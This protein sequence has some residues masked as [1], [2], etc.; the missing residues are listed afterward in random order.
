[1][2]ISNLNGRKTWA[3]RELVW[4]QKAGRG[5]VYIYLYLF[6]SIY[7]YLLLSI[8]IYRIYI[9][10]YLSL[11]LSI[12]IYIY[13]TTYFLGKPLNG[14]ICSSNQPHVWP[15]N[16]DEERLAAI[17]NVAMVRQRSAVHMKSKKNTILTAIKRDAWM[18]CRFKNLMSFHPQNYMRAGGR[19]GHVQRRDCPP[20]PQKKSRVN[21]LF[22]RILQG[23]QPRTSGRLWLV[24]VQSMSWSLNSDGWFWRCWSHIQV[25]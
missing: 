6:L 1:M 18:L 2:F 22:G 13:Y 14:E 7:L 11:S 10:F 8:Y 20:R 5:E 24:T 9:Y 17:P 4:R 3:C 16:P 23:A 19:D 12:S 25:G 15:Q 21:G